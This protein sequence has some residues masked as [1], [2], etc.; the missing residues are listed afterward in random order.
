L[1]LEV[2]DVDSAAMLIRVRQGKGAKDRVVPLSPRLLDELRTYWRAHRPQS[3]LFP[4]KHCG[5]RL[6]PST[7]QRAVRG[8]AQ[9]AG[10]RKPVTPHTLRHSYATSQMQAGVDLLT[11]QRLL[12]HR[13]FQTTAKYVHVTTARLQQLSTP[14]DRLPRDVPGPPRLTTASPSKPW[15]SPR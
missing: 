9:A 6:H 1:G 3:L 13:Q 2:R 4:G 12:G 7:V 10:I 15:N 8:A 11:L 14:L 5:G